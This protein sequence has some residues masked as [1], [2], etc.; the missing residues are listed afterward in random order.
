M[1]R[2]LL[3]A[4][5]LIAFFDA[6]EAEHERVVAWMRPFRGE[7]ITTGAVV[8][9]AFHFLGAEKRALGA[10]VE[11]LQQPGVR[12]LDCFGPE[13]LNR[14]RDLMRKYAAVPMDFADATLVWAAEH[15][16]T[17]DILTLDERGFRT[18]RHG[19]NRM[20]NL[21][22]QDVQFRQVTT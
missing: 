19:R 8:T 13:S 12:V 16:L 9:E 6:G 4:G 18:F 11:F 5:P 10:L 15:S 1:T 3:D 2:C 17:D 20:F 21:V 14:A 7:F 22:I